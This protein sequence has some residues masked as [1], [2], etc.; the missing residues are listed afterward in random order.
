M[1]KV[2]QPENIEMSDNNGS[3]HIRLVWNPDYANKWDYVLHEA[4]KAVDSEVLKQMAPYTPMRTGALID[5]ATLGTVIGSGKI[6]YLS[7]Y[8]RYLYYGE[9]YGPN[10]P[11]RENG[12]L[13]GFWS[14]PQKSPTGRPLVYSQAVHPL[15]GAHW[16]DRMK[17]DRIYT[18]QAAAQA[19]V[20]RAK[21]GK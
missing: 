12:Q 16:F 1:G 4:Q 7:P 9:V 15:A 8:A 2:K 17:T 10:I 13:V 14:P 6:E 11:I 21:K 3:L 5:S 19:A 18:I 20:R